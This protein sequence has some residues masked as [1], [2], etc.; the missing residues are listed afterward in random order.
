LFI[1]HYPDEG[2]ATS[3]TGEGIYGSLQARHWQPGMRHDAGKAGAS[4]ELREAGVPGIRYLDQG[5]RQRAADIAY[6]EKTMQQNAASKRND[7][8]AWPEELARMKQTPL[9]SNYVVFPGN[10]H[11]LTIAKK[12]GLAGAV[13]TM[14]ALAAR[15]RYTDE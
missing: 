3:L 11:L 12:Y 5:S 13:P 15:D 14:G 8:G 1:R 6:A 7:Y 4:M 10:E 9:T 2:A